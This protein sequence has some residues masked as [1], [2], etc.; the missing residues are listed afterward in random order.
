MSKL[1]K[2]SALSLWVLSEDGATNNEEVKGGLNASSESVKGLS[3]VES[4][5][6]GTQV[7]S[8]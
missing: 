4:T 5:S 8:P 3:M 2:P 1:K 6:R 7:I